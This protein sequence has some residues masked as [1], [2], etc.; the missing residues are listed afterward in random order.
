MP[1]QLSIEN[2]NGITSILNLSK[3]QLIQSNG[4]TVAEPLT[5]LIG[6]IRNWGFEG[7]MVNSTDFFRKYDLVHYLKSDTR[8]QYES[9]TKTVSFDGEAVVGELHDSDVDQRIKQEAIYQDQAMRVLEKALEA[10][11]ASNKSVDFFVCLSI[12]P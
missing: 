12:K 7:K 4:P 11:T 8:L 9:A 3:V 5:R 2:F 6:V 10:G 1:E